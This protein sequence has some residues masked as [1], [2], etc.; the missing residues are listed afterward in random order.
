M[1]WD[2]SDWKRAA[3]GVATGG[4]SEIYRGYKEDGIAGAVKGGALGPLG[5]IYGSY[6]ENKEGDE[7]AAAAASSAANKAHQSA[8]MKEGGRKAEALFGAN[9]GQIGDINKRVIAERTAALEGT[10]PVSTR[11]KQ[12]ANIQKR[13]ARAASQAGGKKLSAGEE[14]QIGRSAEQDI[15]DQLYQNKQQ[16]VNAYARMGGALGSNTLS[17]MMGFGGLGAAGQQPMMPSTGGMTV[18]CTELHRQGYISD[19]I[20][21]MDESYGRRIRKSDPLVYI[22]YMVWAPTVVGWMQ[23]SKIVTSIVASL[24]VPWAKDMAYDGSSLGK[25]INKIGSKICRTI[26]KVKTWQVTKPQAV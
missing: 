3:A 5:G 22:G 19:A 6:A 1:G 25:L 26:G 13:A 12:G 9:E 10:D 24:G 16:D 21:E 4:A 23:K 15:A 20:V 7:S 8:M 11:I 17:T 14:A 18:I 2:S